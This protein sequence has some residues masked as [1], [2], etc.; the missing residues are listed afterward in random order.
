VGGVITYE[1]LAVF[2][3]LGIFEITGVGN[4]QTDN[5]IA[6]PGRLSVVMHG[7]GQ[8]F[9]KEGNA[10]GSTGKEV[11]PLVLTLVDAIDTKLT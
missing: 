11:P 10:K 6:S 5:L 7:G 9:L 4:N 3:A 1:A 8:M 2:E